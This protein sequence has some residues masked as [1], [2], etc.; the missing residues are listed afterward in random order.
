MVD[1]W[2]YLVKNEWSCISTTPMRLH[3]VD[4]NITALWYQN[5]QL[6]FITA[7]LFLG[8]FTKL[9]KATISFVVSVRPSQ[10]NN[11]APT[12]RIFMKL[13]VFFRRSVEKIQV[14]LR[15]DQNKGCFT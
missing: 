12:R 6:K 14:S 10:R 4:T 3:D 9:L 8:A 2:P 5:R 13:D 15:S 11:S 1:H 7:Y